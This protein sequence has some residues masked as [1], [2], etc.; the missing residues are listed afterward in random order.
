L[1]TKSL[2]EFIAMIVI[3]PLTWPLVAIPQLHKFMDALSWKSTVQCRI[4][5]VITALIMA[6]VYGWIVHALFW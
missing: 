2:G 3:L 5:I 6:F 1:K 4:V